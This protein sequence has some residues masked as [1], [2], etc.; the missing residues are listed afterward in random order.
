MFLSVPHTVR[1]LRLLICS[2]FVPHSHFSEGA[3]WPRQEEEEENI[4]IGKVDSGRSC[5][6]DQIQKSV[7]R[8]VQSVTLHSAIYVFLTKP[9]VS[10]NW[11]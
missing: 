9:D 2:V 1:A 8:F 5:M 4:E 6:L 11:R 10:C 7:F 3:I